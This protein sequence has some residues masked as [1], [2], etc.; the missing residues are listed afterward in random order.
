MANKLTPT[1]AK[2]LAE[3]VYNEIKTFI[4]A[5]DTTK[6]KTINNS[7]YVK[8]LNK[9][10]VERKTLNDNIN[11]QIDFIKSKFPNIVKSIYVG[12]T[13]QEPQIS[14]QYPYT[15]KESIYNKIMLEGFV[16]QNGETAEQFVKR[17]VTEI[18]KTL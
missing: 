2:I 16:A 4:S 8:K 10:L 5:Q 13:S 9:L 3:E 17:I 1:I 11:D 7:P 15:T 6:L 18:K 12:Y 14:L